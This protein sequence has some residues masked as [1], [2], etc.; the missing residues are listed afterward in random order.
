MMI[1]SIIMCLICWMP[2]TQ[3]ISYDLSGVGMTDITVEQLDPSY[4]SVD[5]SDNNIVTLPANYLINL[6][7]LEEINFSDNDLNL[8]EDFAFENVSTI[9]VND[10]CYFLIGLKSLKKMYF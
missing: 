8:I 2:D 4:T 9:K 3:A 5:F 10:P 7:V 6:P 1:H